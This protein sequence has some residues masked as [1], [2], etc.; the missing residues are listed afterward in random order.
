MKKIKI[1]LSTF[2]VLAMVC[3]L[4][5][6]PLQAFAA[7]PNPLSEAYYTID[8]GYNSS[9]EW[10]YGVVERTHVSI[11]KARLLPNPAAGQ[12]IRVFDNRGITEITTGFAATGMRVKNIQDGAV[13]G[14][15]YIFIIGDVNGDGNTDSYDQDNMMNSS[16]YLT[17]IFK[18]AGKVNHYL[19]GNPWTTDI[20][21]MDVYAMK[22]YVNNHN[23]SH[24]LASGTYWIT[25]EY[26]SQYGMYFHMIKDVPANTTVSVLK[27]L[28]YW[29]PDAIVSSDF[30]IKV[31]NG[32]NEEVT[33]GIITGDMYVK[34]FCGDDYIEFYWIRM[35]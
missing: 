29:S 14:E 21:P 20:T 1:L 25:R 11:L 33:S 12:E 2:V 10:I 24:F 19:Y 32:S 18:E 22:Y 6:L 26:V 15:Y 30:H 28:L 17:G 27:A 8:P 7:T 16:Q 9:L 3:S 31:Y 13:I 35:A 4:F 34:V 5:A 23:L